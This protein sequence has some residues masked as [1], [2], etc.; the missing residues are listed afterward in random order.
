MA[1]EF[2]LFVLESAYGTPMTPTQA[3]MYTTTGTGTAGVGVGGFAGFYARLD[4]SNSFSMRP[5]IVPVEVPYGGGWAAPA[6]TVGDKLTVEGSYST[7]LY[8][9]PFGQFLLLWAAQQ[10]NAHG[11]VAPAG[12]STG[13]WAHSDPPGD[14][15]SVAILHA[16]QRSD[17][18][19]KC[20]QYTGVKVRGFGL[21]ISEGSTAGTLNLQLVG[22]AV[23]GNQWTLGNSVDPTLATFANPAT[24]PLGRGEM[25][26]GIEVAVGGHPVVLQFV[27]KLDIRR[28]MDRVLVQWIGQIDDF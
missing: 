12:V 19:Y 13:A 5:K 15:P 26:R 20:R 1:R 22:S 11:L 17:G 2:A 16:I 24:P 27:M 10:I 23:A 9:G 8:A 7:K 3:E 14:L 4:G 28:P 21:D 18:T 6:I 25:A